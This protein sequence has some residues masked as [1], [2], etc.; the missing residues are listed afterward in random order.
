[1]SGHAA[2]LAQRLACHAEAV[3]RYYLSS[4]RRRGRYG[5]VGDIHNTPGRSLYVRLTGPDYG[6]GAAGKW[7]D[8]ATGEHGDLL[9]LIAGSRGLRQFRDLCAEARQF[10]SLPPPQIAPREAPAMRSSQEAARRL[11]RSGLSISRTHAEAYLRARGITTPLDGMPLRFHPALWYRRDRD[12]AR[13][14]LPGLL[15]AVTDA[16]GRITSVHRTWLDRAHPEKAP[17]P[18]PCRALGHLLGNGVRFGHAGEVLLAGEGIETVLSLKSALPHMPMIAALSANHLAALEFAPGLA[19]L[20][21]AQDRDVAGRMAAER[22]HTRGETAAIDVRDL[23]PVLGDFNEDLCRLGA[24]ILVARL[25]DQL[26][27]ADS[28]RFFSA[29]L[30]PFLPLPRADE[31]VATGSTPVLH[32]DAPG[33]RGYAKH[34]LSRDCLRRS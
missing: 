5:Q 7:T 19:R 9:D 26:A 14:S 30:D 15:A 12:A 1:M 20:Y 2:D 34:G 24:D 3:C 32:G 28:L 21:V 11:F 27:P 17:L 4:G 18:E 33:R 23:I 6:P 10:L 25:S 8:A 16:S 29:K 31:G 22:L 13:E